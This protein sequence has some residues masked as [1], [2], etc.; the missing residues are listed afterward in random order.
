MKKE[1]KAAIKGLKFKPTY[2]TVITIE[3]YY[4]NTGDPILTSNVEF[5]NQ[6][7]AIDFFAQQTKDKT[8][9]GNEVA[10][11]K[12]IEFA[13]GND[14]EFENIFEEYI[15]RDYSEH[16]GKL[17]IQFHHTGKGMNYAH[18]FEGL[19]FLD[20]HNEKDLSI[21]PDNLYRTWTY[22]L[23]LYKESFDGLNEDEAIELIRDEARL[24][25]QN[26]IKIDDIKSELNLIENEVEEYED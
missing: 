3:D 2:Y 9:E 12:R 26:Y 11:F 22:I 15:S 13:A 19:F 7:D 8:F 23:D 1:I 20:K 18:K 24:K 14:D 4:S 17:V 5:K 10:E 21:N 16:Y 6:K 25:L